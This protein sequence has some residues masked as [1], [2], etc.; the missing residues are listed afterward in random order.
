MSRFLAGFALASLLLP[1][2]VHPAAGQTIPSPYRYIEERQEVGVF[3]GRLGSARGLFDYG[4]A[5][6]LS[7]GARYGLEVS[8]PLGL[9]GI[10]TVLPTTR[11]VIHP[12][13]AAGD[14]KVG[15]AE[16]LVT[17]IEARLRF[18]LTGRRTWRG[19][20]PFVVV[21]G[22]MVFDAQ[23]YQAEDDLLA[24]EDQFGLDATFMATMGT[25]ARL[26]IGEHLV[27]RGDATLSLWKLDVPV[28]FEDP[29]RDLG[30]VPESEWTSASGLSVGLAW[31]W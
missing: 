22:G 29:E 25:G 17:T 18:A 12:G 8:G 26:L 30:D 3:V 9:E 24:P 28:G 5:P 2:A 7:F 27:L 4:P 6:G 23:G 11:D 10:V 19:L 20:Q 13:R 15:E 31:R 21:G 16:A 14:R 1:L